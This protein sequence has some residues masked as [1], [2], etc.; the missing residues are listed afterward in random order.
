MRLGYGIAM[1]VA[2]AASA[3]IRPLAWELPYAVDMSLKNKLIN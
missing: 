3:L 1:A 2:Q